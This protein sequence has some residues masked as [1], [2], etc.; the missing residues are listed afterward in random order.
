MPS[1]IFFA[2][3]SDEQA[4]DALATAA[5]KEGFAIDEEQDTRMA[6][7]KGTLLMSILFGIIVVYVK[8]D[9]RVKDDEEGEVRVVIEWTNAWWL[10][11]F[12]PMRA[13]TAMN[14]FADRFETALEN[15]GGDVL[16]RKDKG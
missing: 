12:G 8:A 11:F 7:R 14:G 13:K 4:M 10:G 5:K 6:V 2:K 3:A 16:E 9:I 1:I 15:D